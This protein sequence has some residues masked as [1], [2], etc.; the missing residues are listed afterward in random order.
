MSLVLWP[1]LE[2]RA[3]HFADGSLK[4]ITVE[5]LA[6]FAP[7]SLLLTG[8]GSKWGRTREIAAVNF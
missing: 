3:Q 7:F 8:I 6:A 5:V 2:A 1:S 4:A